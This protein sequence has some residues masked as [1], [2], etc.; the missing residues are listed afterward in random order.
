MR[1]PRDPNPIDMFIAQRIYELRKHARLSRRK[2]ATIVGVS[3]QQIYKYEWGINRLTIGRL[4]S[5]ATAFGI[6]LE[7][8]L[9][10]YEKFAC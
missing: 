2:L 1:L 4:E 5:F 9:V 8:L 3:Q 7:E 6:T 10:N